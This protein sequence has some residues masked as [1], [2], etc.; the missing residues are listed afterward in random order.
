MC[1]ILFRYISISPSQVQGIYW[2]QGESGVDGNSN[3]ESGGTK[4]IMYLFTWY[5]V[6]DYPLKPATK[7]GTIKPN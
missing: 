4:G 3:F 7:S 2:K 6:S 1:F 5:L